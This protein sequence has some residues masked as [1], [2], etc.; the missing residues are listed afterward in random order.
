M[1]KGLGSWV[2]ALGLGLMVFAERFRVYG[3]GI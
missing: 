2:Q 3:L 1:V